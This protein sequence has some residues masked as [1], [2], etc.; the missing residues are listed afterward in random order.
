MINWN[1]KLQAPGMRLMVLTRTP[2]GLVERSATFL[3]LRNL[4]L[5]QGL[6]L[7]TSEALAWGTKFPAEAAN[8]TR[9]CLLQQRIADLRHRLRQNSR[10][11]RVT[12]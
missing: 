3:D 7:T 11:R 10:L 9:I 8:L 1:K 5:V 2:Q 6:D 4:L 12:P